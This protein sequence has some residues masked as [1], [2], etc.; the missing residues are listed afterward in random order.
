MI[1]VK[2]MDLVCAFIILHYNSYEATKVCVDSILGLDKQECVKVIVIDNSSA[3]DSYKKLCETYSGTKVELLQTEYNC[4]FSAANNIAYEYC[5]KKYDCDF[6]IFANND[7][8]FIQKDFVKRIYEEYQNSKF[9]VLG[10]DICNPIIDTHQSPISYEMQRSKSQVKKT[11]IF[12][13]L[14]LTFF[15]LYYMF[16]GKS[17]NDKPEIKDAG[18]YQENVIPL[19]ACLVISKKLLKKKSVVF[20]PETFFYYEEYILADWC[21]KNNEK[22]VYQPAIKVKHYHGMATKT[23]G[24]AKQSELFRMKNIYNSSKIYYK[25]LQ[26]R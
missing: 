2:K 15:D 1:E 17:R 13:R 16:F 3:N 9:A 14:A 21:L 7:L 10:P 20:S 19:G 12:N 18:V 11:I 4:G 26:M 25:Q 23:V 6:V 8:E 24:N 5:K 22:M